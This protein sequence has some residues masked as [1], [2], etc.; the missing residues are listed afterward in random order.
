LQQRPAAEAGR[1]SPRLI[2]VQQTTSSCSRGTQALLLPE[3]HN[4]VRYRLSI[5]SILPCYISSSNFA[6]RTLYMH[7]LCLPC[8]QYAPPISSPP[9]DSDLLSRTCRTV[10][11]PP[12]LM[13]CHVLSPSGSKPSRF[14]AF[15]FRSTDFPW[16]QEEMDETVRLVCLTV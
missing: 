4:P 13:T 6:T 7:F 11:P 12:F 9:A 1:T 16:K 15:P 14:L 8:V 2:L 5:P 10:F 3:P